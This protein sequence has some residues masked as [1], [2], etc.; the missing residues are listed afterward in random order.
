MLGI[1]LERDYLRRGVAE[2]IGTFTLIFIGAGSVS[3]ARTLTDVALAN[4]LAIGVMVCAMGFTSGG[5]FNPAI[6]LGF[7]VTQRIAPSARRL[8]LGRAVRSG[9]DR[10][11]SCSSGCCRPASSR[12]RTSA[13]LP[14][15][16]A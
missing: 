7:L 2:F 1:V 13:C 4:G 3:F 16:E 8:L 14:S 10:R 5:L 9:D 6:T 15:A 11:R 12:S